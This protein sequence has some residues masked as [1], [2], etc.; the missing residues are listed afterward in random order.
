M[1]F[2]I[3]AII[4]AVLLTGGCMDELHS[5]EECVQIETARCE[6]RESCEGELGYKFDYDTCVVYYEEFCRTRKM[7]GPGSAALTQ[8]MVD[9]C[10]A[11]IM[12]VPCKWLN[13]GLDE[14][15]MLPECDFLH[16]D[17]KDGGPDGGTDPDPDAGS[18]GGSDGG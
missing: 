18:D 7:N 8:A 16:T 11:A 12:Q 2:L 10:I 15:D 13:D 17:P 6:L 4:A 9:A 5:Y 14:T 3:M 1:R